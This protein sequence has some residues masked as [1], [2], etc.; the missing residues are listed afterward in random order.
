MI[1]TIVFLVTTLLI[2]SLSANDWTPPSEE[3][4][5]EIRLAIAN[6]ARVNV[7]EGLPHQR[8]EPELLAKESKRKDTVEIASFHFY[9]PAAAA[10]NP[11][12]LKH[13]LASPDSIYVPAGVK[14][15]G[16]FH[17]DFAVE[18]FDTDGARFY[19]L[20]C[21]GCRDVIYSDGKNEYLYALVNDPVEKLRGELLQ[22]SKKRPKAHK[23]NWAERHRARR[24][25]R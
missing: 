21:F 24:V 8:F 10:I 20:I 12:L 2:G 7:Y 4:S 25:G 13:I 9:T 18:C 16:G 3:A 1:R 6:S 5:N 23:G 19:A 22:Y 15:C 11:E 14:A 17:P